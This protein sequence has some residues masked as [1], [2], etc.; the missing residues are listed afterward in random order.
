MKLRLRGFS[1]AARNGAHG[2]AGAGPVAGSADAN[3]GAGRVAAAGGAGAGRSIRA[4]IA[5]VAGSVALA[6]AVPVS[7]TAHAQ[8]LPN[9]GDESAAALSPQMERKIGEGIYREL[10]RDPSYVEDAEVAG[11]VQDMGQRLLAAGPEPGM[12]VEFFVLQDAQINAFALL[13]GYIGVNSGLIV[14]AESESEAAS[15]LGHEIGHLTQKHIA[16][17]VAA[18]QRSSMATLVMSAFCL[19]AARSNP[20]VAGGC[21]MAGQAAGVQSQL[22]Y[23]RDFEREADRVGFDIL[24]KGGFD[25]S[26]M[27]V[28]FERMQRSTRILES[29]APA[30][31]RSHPLTTERIADVRNRVQGRGGQGGAQ[32]GLQS[33]A[34]GGIYRQRADTLTFHLVRAKLRATADATVDGVR[35]SVKYFRTQLDDKTLAHPAAAYYGL[36]QAYLQGRDVAAAQAAFAR[37][38]NPASHPMFETLAARIRR[39]AGDND[40]ALALLHAAIKRHAAAPAAAAFQARALQFEMIDALQAAGKHAEALPLLR[41]QAQLY[42][43]DPRVQQLL[44]KSYAATG[45]R[46][47]QHQALGE[48][49][50]LLGAL[51]AAI[52]QYQLARCSGEGDFYQLSIIDARIRILWDSLLSERG[53]QAGGRQPPSGEGSSAPRG[54]PR[55][56][57]GVPTRC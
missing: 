13:G 36:A 19:L 40:G 46:L 33:G 41:D 16:R 34:Q 5:A 30:Y 20:Q 8:N 31:V 35:D 27:P 49:Y 25:V 50:A 26:A 18:G 12:S 15:V 24:N 11:Y 22:A 54:P 44:A 28:F 2:I 39:A 42:R 17:G 14:A 29:N 1:F 45:K 7:T 32:G 47:A 37:I 48:H 6:A 57:Q 3:G 43:T 56:E 9:L 10:R 38:A 23:S 4:L 53:D 51:Q 52:E 21:L 55:V